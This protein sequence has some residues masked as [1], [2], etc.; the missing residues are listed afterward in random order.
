MVKGMNDVLK[1]I[2]YISRSIFYFNLVIMLSS[3]CSNKQLFSREFNNMLTELSLG[4]ISLYKGISLH[5]RIFLI[6]E[7]APF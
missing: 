3:A 4:N 2:V 6:L 5:S 1:F 7:H